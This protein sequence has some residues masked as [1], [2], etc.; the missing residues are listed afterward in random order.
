[1]RVNKGGLLTV[2]RHVKTVERTIVRVNKMVLIAWLVQTRQSNTVVS[3]GCFS[4]SC[5][6]GEGNMK[7][8]KCDC[9][10]L[11]RP[12]TFVCCHRWLGVTTMQESGLIFISG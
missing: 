4:N 10:G 8:L 5:R 2:K 6:M 1:M 3:H 7:Q 12:G 9:A 11:S